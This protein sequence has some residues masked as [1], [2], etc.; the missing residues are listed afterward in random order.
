MTEAGLKDRLA[1]V[2]RDELKGAVVLRHED[3]NTAGIPDLSVTWRLLDT[4]LEV[5]YANPNLYHAKDLQN[6]TALRLAMTGRCMYVIYQEKREVK[7]TL[8]VHPS[9]VHNRTIDQTPDEFVSLGFDHGLVVQYIRRTH[10]DR[11]R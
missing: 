3:K 1:R 5:K 8:I 9:L 4:W 6:L 10:G 2:L 7:R 11:I